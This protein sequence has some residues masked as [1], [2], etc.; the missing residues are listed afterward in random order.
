MKRRGKVKRSSLQ[1]NIRIRSSSMMKTYESLISNW[2]R[3]KL[4]RKTLMCKNKRRDSW[5]KFRT[6][7]SVLIDL[8]HEKNIDLWLD[9]K[10]FRTIK[11]R[12]FWKHRERKERILKL[13]LNHRLL[14]KNISRLSKRRLKSH[15]RRNLKDERLLSYHQIHT[16]FWRMMIK[17]QKLGLEGI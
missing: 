4:I 16:K 5:S 14:L 15:C 7:Q 11:L 3:R 6:S 1:S 9:C 2:S 13:I 8:K 10:T 12:Q 17:F